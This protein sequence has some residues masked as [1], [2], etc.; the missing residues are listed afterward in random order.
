MAESFNDVVAL[1][2]AV[3]A[4]VRARL[5]AL[6]GPQ[7]E[8]KSQSLAERL[9]ETSWWRDGEWAVSYTHLTLPTN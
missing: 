4:E 5:A 8:G 9:F 1:K 3:R 6:D 2:R 7:I